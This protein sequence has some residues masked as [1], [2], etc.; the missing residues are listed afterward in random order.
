MYGVVKSHVDI[1]DAQKLPDF[2]LF[3]SL[4]E[5]LIDQ[6]RILPDLSYY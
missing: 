3:E 5:F 1:L 2:I 4:F 6:N